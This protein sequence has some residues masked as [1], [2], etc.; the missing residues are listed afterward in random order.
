MKTMKKAKIALA[1]LLLGAA[2]GVSSVS[3]SADTMTK[4]DDV[5]ANFAAG[6]FNDVKANLAVGAF[7]D[8]NKEGGSGD[9]DVFAKVKLPHAMTY[10]QRVFF[11]TA[12]DKSLK[13]I[14]SDFTKVMLDHTSKYYGLGFMAHYLGPLDTDKGRVEF[15]PS[16]SHK[17]DRGKVTAYVLPIVNKGE[18]VRIGVKGGVKLHDRVKFGGFVEY[19]DSG[20]W[21]ANP[22]LS[23]KVVDSLDIMAG[24]L[25]NT[26]KPED[27]K[28]SARAGLK[29]K[30]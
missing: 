25:I 2:L 11:N 10:T 12:R 13:K 18:D 27:M 21:V 22:T 1:T 28:Y 4:T 8:L 24:S 6:S 5:K 17:F 19:L 30:F 29:Y 16:I 26:L 20:N 3:M 23:F 9:L 14:D 15:G 7:Y